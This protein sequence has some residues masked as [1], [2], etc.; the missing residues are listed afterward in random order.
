MQEDSCLQE[1]QGVL[2]PGLRV[3]LVEDEPLIGLAAESV[4]LSMGVAQ[5]TRVRNVDEAM[6]QIEEQSFNA[7]I[8]D[9]KLGQES[10]L[11][12]AQLLARLGIPHGFLTGYLDDDIPPEVRDRPKVS[13]PFSDSQ[14]AQLLQDLVGS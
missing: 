1:E 14:L 11:P 13:K 3:L 12:L 5:V 4:L 6:R 7:A 9:L 10:S 8:L 2:P